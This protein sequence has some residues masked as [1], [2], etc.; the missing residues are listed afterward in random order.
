[1]AQRILQVRKAGKKKKKAAQISPHRKTAQLPSPARRQTLSRKVSCFL[2]SLKLQREKEREK[3]KADPTLLVQERL[4]RNV[5]WV[6]RSQ[7]LRQ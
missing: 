3:S 4:S 1:M 2:K 6:C 5:P 7:G